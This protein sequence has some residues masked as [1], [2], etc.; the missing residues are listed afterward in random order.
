[1]KI[2]ELKTRF[3]ISWDN[4]L[5]DD[6]DALRGALAELGSVEDCTPK[7]TVV[8][9]EN[10]REIS[11]DDLCQALKDKLD[12]TTGAAVFVQLGKDNGW[13]IGPGT[14]DG[15]RSLVVP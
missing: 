4:P 1:V 3:L 8:L 5:G 2:S 6:H 13:Q 7:T 9:K 12:P 15:W 10:A 11:D 14:G